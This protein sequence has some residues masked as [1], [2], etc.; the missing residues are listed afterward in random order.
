MRRIVSTAVRLAENGGFDGVRLRDVAEQS[1][2]ALGTLYKYFR[3][4]EDILLF[5]LSEELER[6]E[7]GLAKR[8]A[9]GRTKLARLSDLFQRATRGLIRRPPFARAALRSMAVG[10]RGTALKI[11]GYQLR[12]TRLVVAALHGEPPDLKAP[13]DPA[14][15]TER[16]RSIAFALQNVWF[17]TLVGWAVGL[18]P[19]EKILEHV[20]SAA[21]LMLQGSGD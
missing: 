6:L 21:T 10:D 3:S 14:P 18:H 4:K 8:P 15:G 9:V 20:H 19:D 1:D 13:L 12:V 11:A 17:S 16:E 5:A 7:G 2:V